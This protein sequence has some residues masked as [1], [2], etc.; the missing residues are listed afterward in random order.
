[1][2]QYGVLIGSFIAFAWCR[3]W[4][5]GKPYSERGMIHEP[6]S[7]LV[8]ALMVFGGPVSNCRLLRCSK[9]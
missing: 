9:S 6:V 5:V 7:I 1:M 8:I 2:D 3:L 4:E